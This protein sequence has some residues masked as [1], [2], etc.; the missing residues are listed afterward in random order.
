MASGLSRAGC[1]GSWLACGRIFWVCIVGVVHLLQSRARL[2][3]AFFVIP[4]LLRADC[5]F[6]RL[7]DRQLPQVSLLHTNLGIAITYRAGRSRHDNVTDRGT[8]SNG[9]R[10]GSGINC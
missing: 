5:D 3:R 2:A 7:N 10:V 9:Y 6:D 4:S 1:W 8:V